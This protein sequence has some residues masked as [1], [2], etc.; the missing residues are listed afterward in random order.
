MC[1]ILC[2]WLT[3]FSL[4]S[5]VEVVR[6]EFSLGQQNK[7][8]NVL[9]VEHMH[10]VESHRMQ[11]DKLESS[12]NNACLEVFNV[13]HFFLLQS[14]I[15]WFSCYLLQVHCRS[16]FGFGCTKWASLA[17]GH[18]WQNWTF[19]ESSLLLAFNLST[20]FTVLECFIITFLPER[21][22]SSTK[23]LYKTNATYNLDMPSTGTKF[24][25]LMNFREESGDEMRLKTILSS[26]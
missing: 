23:A 10:N 13:W 8:N 9:F 6:L 21:N 20:S 16:I 25:Q 24:M 5:N 11:K 7:L 14:S 3:P 26:D 2:C 1:S 17:R 19:E 4:K 12:P 22:Q 18:N 15:L